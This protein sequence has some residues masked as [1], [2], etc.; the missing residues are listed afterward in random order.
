MKNF[1]RLSLLTL[2]I[3]FLAA[4]TRSASAPPSADAAPRTLPSLTPGV[5]FPLALSTTWIYEMETHTN[6]QSA[7]WR[8]TQTIEEIGGEA[9]ILS[10]RVVQRVTLLSPPG[11]DSGQFFSPQNS[12][13]WY[14]LD[15]QRLYRQ[16]N[17]PDFNARAWGDLEIVWPPESLPCWCVSASDGCLELAGEIGPGCRHQTDQESPSQ[18]PAGKFSDCRSL[19][20][21]YNNGGEQLI[22]CPNVGIAAEKYQHLGD[23]FGYSMEL[24]GYSLPQP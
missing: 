1:L 10:A 16:E 4:C 15:Q 2:W 3:F 17:A 23:D 8:L 21:G 6:G 14:I 5:P 20:R 24:I 12:S 22:F 11:S 19:Q 7:R 9:G 13:F 18:F